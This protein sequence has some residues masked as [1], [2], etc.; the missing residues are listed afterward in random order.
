MQEIN[1]QQAVDPKALGTQEE[2]VRKLLAELVCGIRVDEAPT[3]ETKRIA[4]EGKFYPLT[5]D[6]N[7][8]LRVSLPEGTKV[9]TQELEVLLRIEALLE[10]QVSLLQEIA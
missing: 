9:E 2:I 6:K 3:S 1:T 7:G 5:I 8:F 10:Q 4:D